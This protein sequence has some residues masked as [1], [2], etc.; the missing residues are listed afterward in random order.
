MIFIDLEHKKP[1]DADI[2]GWVPWSQT[3]W[4]AWLTK[5]RQLVTDMAALEAAGKRD[6]RNALIA[7]NGAHWGALK[8]WMLAL[9][10][11]KCWFSEVR[12]LYSHY[13]VEHFRPK[14]EA[15]ALDGTERDGYWWLAFDY[16]N[17][18]VCGNVGNRKKGGWFPLKDGS[19]CSS[20]AAPCEESEARYLLDP[21]DDDDVSLIAFD[22]EGKVIPAPGTS[23]WEKKR[24][25]VTV[26][27]LKLNEHA[28]L[29]E[30]RRKIWQK[31]NGLIEDF[32]AAKAK[33]SHGNNPAAKAKLLEVRS[34]V[35]EMTKRSAEL[36]AVARW[37]IQ[38]RNEP[39]LLRLVA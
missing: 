1:T 12:E 19:L 36:S 13:D 24:V 29:A 17:L 15:R 39:Q 32:Y 26:E 31:V 11:G 18:R 2:P 9:S 7:A 8:E 37:C 16:M 38:V 6:E 35:R 14:K 3:Q 22:E 5:S 33:C 27:R 30:E 21:I 10:G 4:D 28:P 25:H 23:D 34:R 20:Y